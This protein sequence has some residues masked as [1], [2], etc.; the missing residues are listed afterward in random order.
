MFPSESVESSC[1]GTLYI[2]T[3]V[4]FESTSIESSVR[5][6]LLTSAIFQRSSSPRRCSNPCS[7][8]QLRTNE[9]SP[10]SVST[11]RRPALP[12]SPVN[13]RHLELPVLANREA[14]VVPQLKHKRD[15]VSRYFITGIFSTET[16]PVHVIP[17][18]HLSTHSA[19]ALSMPTS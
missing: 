18:P 4:Y 1:I 3:L 10:G 17:P 16:P 7:M 11:N 8:M 6:R 9:V 14:V 15:L 13:S 2:L 12:V 5:Y 19:A